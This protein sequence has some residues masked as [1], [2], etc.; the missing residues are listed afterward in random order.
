MQAQLATLAHAQL[1]HLPPMLLQCT[2]QVVLG[3]CRPAC[4]ADY[5]E[6]IKQVRQL[7][8]GVYTATFRARWIPVQLKWLDSLG[9]A[10]PGVRVE[11]FDVLDRYDQRSRF[12][13]RAL[14]KLFAT[15]ATT[16]ILRVPE[17]AITGQ[18]S[19]TVTHGRVDSITERVSLVP[20][21][22]SFQVK[23]QRLARDIVQWYQMR[24]P[25]GTGYMDWYDTVAD[26]LHIDDVP[27]M[28]QFDID[29]LD[30]DERS[31]VYTSI[32]AFMSL[33]FLVLMC[34]GLSYGLVHMQQS[35]AG[36]DFMMDNDIMLS[37]S[38]W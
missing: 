35:R 21:F 17:S 26:A 25:A 14:F 4:S 34:F 33:A 23:N 9:H 36:H 28:G 11:Y 8:P 20:L 30:Q 22:K 29:G 3:S 18:L 19:I 13:W 6:H 15:A 24:R 5:Q 31:G 1:A 27:G 7:E 16:G 10:W 32:F 38:E 37:Y 12:K 2:Q